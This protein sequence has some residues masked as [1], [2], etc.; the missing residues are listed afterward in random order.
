MLQLTVLEFTIR[1][2]P[3][4]LVYIFAAYVFSNK[5]LDV[6]KYLISSFLLAIGTFLVRMLPINYGVHTIL[7]IIIQM[8][9]FNKFLFI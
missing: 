3:E 4:A 5:K 7:A 9:I 1:T 6:N 8:V 2:I